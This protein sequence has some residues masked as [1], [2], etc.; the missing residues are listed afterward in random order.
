MLWVM[1]RNSLK[2]F[3]LLKNDG[4]PAHLIQPSEQYKAAS[5][6]KYNF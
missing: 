5:F 1:Q 3:T 6:V 2:H 4:R